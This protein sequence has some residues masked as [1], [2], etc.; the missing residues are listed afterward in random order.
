MQPVD[1]LVSEM[2]PQDP[3]TSHIA[4]DGLAVAGDLGGNPV[5]PVMYRAW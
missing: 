4:D 1:A 3:A 5:K 2:N